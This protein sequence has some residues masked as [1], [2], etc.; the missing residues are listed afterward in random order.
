VLNVEML[1]LVMNFVML[2][3]VY[4]GHVIFIVMLS[5]IMLRIVSCSAT[6]IAYLAT[7]EHNSLK[8]IM[9]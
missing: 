8:I 2:S 3:D 5:V 1:G 6:S 4:G 9:L 7:A